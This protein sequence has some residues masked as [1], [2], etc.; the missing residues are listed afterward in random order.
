MRAHLPRLFLAIRYDSMAERQ[1]REWIAPNPHLQWLLAPVDT[2]MLQSRRADWIRAVRLVQPRPSPKSVN[3][4]TD[5]RLAVVQR[6][7]VASSHP[8]NANPSRR[9]ASPNNHVL[10]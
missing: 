5:S 1:V 9:N 3:Y 4:P 10:F 2:E 8:R 7:R 6:D